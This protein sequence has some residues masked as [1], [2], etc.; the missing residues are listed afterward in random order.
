MT[1]HA[2]KGLEFPIVFLVGMEDGMFPSDA[3]IQEAGRIEEERR[4]AYVGITRA[5]K[6]LYMLGAEQRMIYG[7]TLHM[8]PSRFL[9]D[10]PSHLI[11]A[12]GPAVEIR[13]TLGGY[14]TSSSNYGG[15]GT[16]GMTSTRK[17][18]VDDNIDG[19]K[20]GQFVSHPKFGDGVIQGFEGVGAST[21]VIVEFGKAGRKVLV[22]SYANLTVM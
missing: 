6:L 12:I 4:L 13:Q 21:R 16:K 18:A 8:P 15:F 2:S 20:I 10:I 22:L 11:Q 14:G 17:V 9:R 19:Y 7:K 1:L 3:A 5:E